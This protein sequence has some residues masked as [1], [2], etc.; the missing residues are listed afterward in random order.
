MEG[1]F[2]IGI[3]VLILIFAVSIALL[4]WSL[5]INEIVKLLKSANAALAEISAL[6]KKTPG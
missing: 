5:R 3:F 4:R 1:T 6:L 2:G